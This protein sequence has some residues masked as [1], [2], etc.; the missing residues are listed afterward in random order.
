[1]RLPAST[2]RALECAARVTMVWVRP[3][4]DAYATGA[5][6]FSGWPAGCA[7]AMISSTGTEG[8]SFL[9]RRRL[10]GRSERDAHTRCCAGGARRGAITMAGA[11]ALGVCSAAPAP[12]PAPARHRSSVVWPEHRLLASVPWVVV[13]TSRLPIF[14]GQLV[15]TTGRGRT[16]S[17]T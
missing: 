13:S 7:R 17:F 10:T 8:I 3:V 16:W 1:M 2:R 4:G 14:W 5:P 15:A 12:A 11:C 9:S 6:A